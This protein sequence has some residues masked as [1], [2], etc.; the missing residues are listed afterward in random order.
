MIELIEFS[1]HSRT[2]FGHFFNVIIDRFNGLMSDVRDCGTE[3]NLERTFSILPKRINFSFAS[4][5]GSATIFNV[6]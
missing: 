6:D 1:G 2:L 3:R 4:L 5:V